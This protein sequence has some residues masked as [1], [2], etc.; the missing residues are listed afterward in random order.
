[1]IYS[2]RGSH[3]KLFLDFDRKYP[4]SRTLALSENYR[5][6]PQILAAAD[7][8]IARNTARHP[9]TLTATKPAGPRPLYFHAK[10][11][12]DEAAWIASRIEELRAGGAALGDIAL[13]YRAHYLSRAL[14][15][16][17]FDK[18]LPYKIY[19]GV[20]FYGR[21][22]IKDVISYLRMV[23]SGDDLAFLRTINTPPRKIGK[24]KIDALKARAEER[25]LSLYEALKENLSAPL[26]AGSQARQYVEAIEHLR[27]KRAGLRLDDLLQTLLDR[28]GYEEFLRLQGDQ[29]RLDNVAEL[30]RAVAAA[31]ADEDA[32][33]EDFL[34]RAALFTNLDGEERRDSVKLMTIHAAK[35]MEFPHVF[36]CGLSEGV[37]PGRR[38]ATLE[39][40]EEERRLAYVAATRAMTRLFL[41]DAEGAANDGIFKYPSRFIFDMGAENIDHAVPLDASLEENARAYIQRD[42][43]A[44]ALRRAAFARGERVVHP[45]FGAGAIVAVNADGLYYAIQFDG[46]KTERNIQFGS[47]LEPESVP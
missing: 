4:E 3:V 20:E 10:S 29:E 37:F 14:E 40:M 36:L 22:E 24:K 8:L 35:G 28:S 2:W 33:L 11:E 41:S 19:S 9:K 23:A 31:S 17:L 34:A 13:L 7:A 16:S 38:V 5:S 26:L 45:V 32:T 6:S 12:R 43:A 39:A 46:L 42:E 30:K 18:G 27:G 44:L 47:T 25:K 15:E 21:K 1:T